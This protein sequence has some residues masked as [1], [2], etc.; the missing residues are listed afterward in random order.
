MCGPDLSFCTHTF[1]PRQAGQLIKIRSCINK[2]PS[3][4]WAPFSAAIFS[5]F[6]FG[7]RLQI[8][9]M[10]TEWHCI[11]GSQDH[12]YKSTAIQLYNGLLSSHRRAGRLLL[13]LP[14]ELLGYN[15]YTLF[16]GETVKRRRKAQTARKLMNYEK[17]I[18]LRKTDFFDGGWISHTLYTLPF[19]SRR[20]VKSAVLESK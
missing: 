17:L 2:S 4:W 15:H 12:D 20:S 16:S 10:V 1:Y 9:D 11:L 13:Q 8:D 6:V 14:A 7:Q 3:C 18:E 5:L 19:F